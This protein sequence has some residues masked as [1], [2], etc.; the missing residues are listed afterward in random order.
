MDKEIFDIVILS[1][2][3]TGLASILSSTLGTALSLLLFFKKGRNYKRVVDI[4]RSLTGIPT[5]IYGLI[6]LLLLSRRG[7]L[8]GLNLLFTP[9]AIVVAQFF[10]LLPLIITLC[11]E[12]LET[13]G[14]RLLM[15]CKILHIPKK[16]YK[17]IFYRELKKRFLNIFLVAFARGI[18]EVGAVMIVGG[19]IKGHTRVMTTY[20]ALSNSMGDY[21]TSLQIAVVLFLISLGL[22]I[23]IK[24]V[25]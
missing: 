23:L 11:S 9:T 4:F 18:S 16:K 12:V 25:K 2:L 1:I 8:G 21:N 14:E 3:V 7:I 10:L 24:R 15:L 5:I 6:V 17:I 19:N 20:I 13:E 22:N